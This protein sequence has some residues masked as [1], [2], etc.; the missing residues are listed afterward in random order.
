MK[1]FI[2]GRGFLIVLLSIILVERADSSDTL[3][4][5]TLN[6]F[7]IAYTTANPKAKRDLVIEA[8]DDGIIKRGLPLSE[9]S[10]LFGKDM[11]VY[12]RDSTNGVMDATI[13]FEP[14][15]P[16]PK[17]FMSAVQEGWYLKMVFSSD[18]KLEYYSLSNLHK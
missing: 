11:Q 16:A 9:A 4:V 13:F 18:Y 2:Y 5:K 17:P 3:K 10:Q 12:R 7:K 14:V 8:V 6:Q 1:A 15:T